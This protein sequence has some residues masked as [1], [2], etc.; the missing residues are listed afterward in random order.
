MT[1]S[2]HIYQ[3]GD[4]NNPVFFEAILPSNKMFAR[5]FYVEGD[6]SDFF[7]ARNY[8][9]N[10]LLFGLSLEKVIHPILDFQPEWI[11]T[12]YNVPWGKRAYWVKVR[13]E[14]QPFKARIGKGFY[15]PWQLA[16]IDTALEQ[17]EHKLTN[18]SSDVKAGDPLIV[19]DALKA[20]FPQWAEERKDWNLELFSTPRI[21]L[22]EYKSA[23]VTTRGE[24][25]LHQ[26]S[27]VADESFKTP[28]L[29]EILADRGIK[30]DDFV[31]TCL[32]VYKHYMQQ[33]G[34]GGMIKW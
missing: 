23:Y 2:R 1:S 31:E 9:I 30:S 24:D 10:A 16:K 28:T 17:F 29:N 6:N 20:R 34:L 33:K 7:N 15:E 14:E 8:V 18:N 3:K 32:Q 5:T 22:H 25:G 27:L 12:L 26:Q 4:L 21:L 11:H 13:V 19:N